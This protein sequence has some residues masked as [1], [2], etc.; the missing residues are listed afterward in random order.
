MAFL[1]PHSIF[2]IP[3]LILATAAVFQF[4]IMIATSD[5]EKTI[6]E[7]AISALADWAKI[8]LGLVAPLL[9]IGAAIETWVT[10]QIAVMLLP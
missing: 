7:V 3:G 2:E 10:P 5:A 1:L 6:G 9:L 8:M 4:G